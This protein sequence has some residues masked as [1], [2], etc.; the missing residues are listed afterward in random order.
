FFRGVVSIARADL[1]FVFQAAHFEFDRTKLSIASFVGWII[2]ETVERADIGGDTRERGPRIGE[3]R[4]FKTSSTGRAR[5]I[6]HLFAGEIVERAADR[7]SLK[8]THLAEAVEILFLRLR[9]KELAVS[10]NL[11]FRQRE[12]SVVLAIFHQ[13]IFDEVFGV[14]LDE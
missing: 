4:G 8:R 14:H 3:S 9:E 12:L 2:T 1:G 13:A 7:H 6:I 10:L 5:E 11:F